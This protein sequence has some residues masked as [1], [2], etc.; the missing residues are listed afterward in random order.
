M[1]IIYSHTRR[2]RSFL[3]KGLKLINVVVVNIKRQGEL[4]DHKG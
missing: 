1:Y 3:I 4:R 2:M